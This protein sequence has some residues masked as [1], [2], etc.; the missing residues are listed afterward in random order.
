MGHLNQP[1]Y[2]F[3]AINNKI[4]AEFGFLLKTQSRMRHLKAPFKKHTSRAARNPTL[5]RPERWHL[6]TRMGLVLNFSFMKF[7]SEKIP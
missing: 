2:L 7:A 5:F 4:P 3:K 1:D 6:T